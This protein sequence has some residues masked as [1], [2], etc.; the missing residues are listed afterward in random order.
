MAQR[1]GCEAPFIRPAE[2][3]DD[4]ASSY[5]VAVHAIESLEE[6]FD[7]LVMLQPT[8]PLRNADDIDSCIELCI[9][10]GSCVSLVESNKSPHWMY[11]LS[12][13]DRMIPILRSGKAI[14]RRQDSPPVFVLN[15]AV[16]AVN[17]NWLKLNGAFIGDETVPYVMPLDRSLDIDTEDDLEIF[18]MRMNLRK[19]D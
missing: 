3:A 8:S 7:I 12:P 9:E 10:T 15:G 1:F 17:C 16:Y 13:V 11:T 2:L 19:R 18:E 5:N 6:S 4:K 14:L